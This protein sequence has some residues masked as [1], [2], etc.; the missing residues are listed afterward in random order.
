MGGRMPSRRDQA[1]TQVLTGLMQDDYPLTLQHVLRRARSVYRASDVR[2]LTQ[3]GVVRARFG[4]LAQRVD[5]LSAA[6][7][8]LGVRPGDR[9]GT[10]AWNTQPHLELYLSV[11]CTGAVL[12]TLNLRLSPQQL[13]YV[14]GHADD[15]VVFVEDDLVP[16]LEPV[17]G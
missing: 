13:A 4:E 14:I 10:L 8:G 3:A 7:S 11:P 9:V 2:T 5:Q 6:L 15:Q 12:H 17:L 16:L 1:A